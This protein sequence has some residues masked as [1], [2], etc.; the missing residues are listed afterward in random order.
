MF[1]LHFNEEKIITVGALPDMVVYSPDG[2]FILT[3]NE[4]EPNATYTN[5]PE[6]SVS[7]I[8]VANNYAVKTVNFSAFSSGQTAWMAASPPADNWG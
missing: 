8:D 2:K 5:D 1:L 7:I 4:G 6:G 3:A